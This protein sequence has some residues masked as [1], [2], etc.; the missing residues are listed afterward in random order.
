MTT[1]KSRIRR[2]FERA[3]SSYDG[4]AVLQREV[5]DRMAER[6]ELIKLQP[7][8]ILDAGS[9]T[10]YGARALRQRYDKARVIELDLALPMLQVASGGSAW[11]QKK[12]PFLRASRPPQ[13]CGDVENLP[14]ASNS[15]D[16]I[17]SNLTLQWLTPPDRAFGELQ[18]VLR[19]DGVLMF[20]TLGPDTLKELRQAFAGIDS[21][22]HVNRFIDMHDVGDALVH[23]GFSEPV[24]DMEYITL[25]YESVKA[26]LLDLKAIGAQQLQDGRN[27]GLMGKSRW[28]QLVA[29]YER[30][31]RDGRLPATYEV[32]YGHAWKAQPRPGKT[33]P[34]GRRIVE[35]KP[36]PK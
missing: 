33:L 7:A 6:L 25:T 11:W 21:F 34:D 4:A 26:V 29:A 31:R 1:S 2:S 9:G 20:S 13:V 22:G 14:L 27:P 36:R 23:A 18:R 28:S 8:T 10:G 15:V 24:M 3:A 30:L 19:P 32:V 17:W 35:F 5:S 12:L 16:M